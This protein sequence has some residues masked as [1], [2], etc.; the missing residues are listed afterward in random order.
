MILL[1]FCAFLFWGVESARIDCELKKD[2]EYKW[3]YS[4]Y[5]DL[6]YSRLYS[7]G[8]RIDPEV[9]DPTQ[10]NLTIEYTKNRTDQHVQALIYKTTAIPILPK[11]VFEKFPNMTSSYFF[12]LNNLSATEV[13][14]DWFKHA[15]NLTQLF[16][17]MNN[18]PTLG[19]F[20]FT[21]LQN[22][23][24][25]D[26]Y[27]CR[28]K[29]FDENTFVGLRKLEIL[30]LYNNS[31]THLHSD[32]FKD[33]VSLKELNMA[34][35]YEMKKLGTGVFRN[36]V[37]LEKLQMQG[38][39][40]G[41]LPE[42]LFKNNLNLKEI[43]LFRAK[44]SKI[45]KNSFTHLKS[46]KDLELKDNYCVTDNFYGIKGAPVNLQFVEES[47]INCSCDLAEEYDPFGK[48]KIF[49]IYFG[50]I[51]G[52]VLLI[53]VCH[54]RY[55]QARRASPSTDNRSRKWDGKMF[56]EVSSHLK[57]ILSICSNREDLRR[58]HEEL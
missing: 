21:N 22:L 52:I 32:T 33:L 39:E 13:H 30:R 6:R 14:Q 15:R 23:V 54:L 9:L 7:C 3:V 20:L 27:I 48:L 4:H 36:L 49:M 1:I 51:A 47:L 29:S 10:L 35:N 42:G 28:I 17:Y 40:L 46:L 2:P 24:E 44:I 45:P 11:E 38:S 12:Q 50:G 31:L 56:S 34:F 18:I 43:S 8:F 16:F 19:P 41:S 5:F 25:L 37:K 58:L 57:N 55:N 53:F 26:L